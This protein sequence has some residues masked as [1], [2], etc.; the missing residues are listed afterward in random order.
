MTNQ[1]ISRGKIRDNLEAFGIAILAAVLLKYFAIE[2][3]QIPT[4]SMQPTLMGSVEAGVHDRILVDKLRYSFTEPKRWDVVVFRY[5]LQQN[6]NYVKRLVG[7]PGDRIRILGGNLYLVDENRQILE[8]LSKPEHVQ[9]AGLWKEVY[10]LQRYL[11][12]S[13]KVLDYFSPQPPRSW[14]QDGDDLVVSTSD[15]RGTVLT[16][17]GRGASG[18]FRGVVNDIHDGYPVSVSQAIRAPGTAGY[19]VPDVRLSA[20]VTPGQTSGFELEFLIRVVRPAHLAF[21]FSLRIDEKGQGHLLVHQSTDRDP[22][23]AGE[24]F[25][26]QLTAGEET[27]IAFAH[28]DDQLTCWRDGDIVASLDTSGFRILEGLELPTA[29]VT[30]EIEI[31]GGGETRVSDLRIERDLHY[32]RST[33]APDHLIQV[34][35]D[36]YFMMGDNTLQSVDSRDWTAIT[37]GLLPDGTMVDPTVHPQAEKLKG[38]RRPVTPTEPPDRDET[39]IVIPSVDTVVMIDEFGNV[40]RMK[41]GVSKVYATSNMI[42][43]PLDGNDETGWTPVETKVHFVPREHIIGR[44]FMGFWPFPPFGPNRAGFIK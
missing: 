16:F 31:W 20:A 17:S 10:P 1:T 15:G 19:A 13:E 39:P 34:P 35:E 8:V 2:A 7:T 18:E 33:L 25:D 23:L 40:R 38:N 9:E 5:P 3:Y 26:F 41:S 24:P 44:A 32:T 12:A 29:K 21:K 28:H 37:V 27:V 6:Q 22:A 14:R 36:H 42:F 4:S 11:N 43:Q 30:P